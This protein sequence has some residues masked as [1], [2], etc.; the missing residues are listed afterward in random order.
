MTASSKFTAISALGRA[1][2]VLVALASAGLFLGVGLVFGGVGIVDWMFL[3]LL[4]LGAIVSAA[5]GAWWV[6]RGVLGRM[7]AA[8][9]LFFLGPAFLISSFSYSSGAAYQVY[10][11]TVGPEYRGPSVGPPMRFIPGVEGGETVEEFAAGLEPAQRAWELLKDRSYGLSPNI[12]CP[13]CPPQYFYTVLVR[14]FRW[15]PHGGWLWVTFYNGRLYRA[16]FGVDDPSAEFRSVGKGADGVGLVQQN[17]GTGIDHDPAFAE[18]KQS[19]K[20]DLLRGQWNRPSSQDYVQ[21]RTDNGAELNLFGDG[22]TVGFPFVQWED[23]RLGAQSSADYQKL[24]A[25]FG[26]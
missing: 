6:G 5:A 18:A 11:T 21:G 7:T 10:G 12:S 16:R 8:L 17:M 9:I 23:P 22:H 1:V 14:D 26:N 4:A 15:G 2:L 3:G 13:R 24:P 20:A 25:V 19:L